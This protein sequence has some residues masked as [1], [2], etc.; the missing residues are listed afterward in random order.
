[1]STAGEAASLFGA[2][3]T[4]SDPFAVALGGEDDAPNQVTGDVPASDVAA[5][6]FGSATDAFPVGG[7][8]LEGSQPAAPAHHSWYEPPGQQ[9]YSYDNTATSTYAPTYSDQ[10]TYSQQNGYSQYS[11]YGQ[12]SAP[13][14]SVYEP[15]Y[16]QPQSYAPQAYSSYGQGDSP[17]AP[18]SMQQQAPTTQPGTYSA[19]AYDPYKPS[20]PTSSYDPPSSHAA[21]SVS[22]STY[23][24]YKPSYTA[25]ST[26]YEPPA[27]QAS[28]TSSTY[29]PGIANPP[30]AIPPPPAPLASAPAPPPPEVKVETYRPKKLNAYDPP[31]PPIKAPKHVPVP[32]V[33][34]FN[35]PP[36]MSPPRSTF[37][38]Q[39]LQPPPPTQGP[40]RS[41]RP[42]AATAPPRRDTQSSVQSAVPHHPPGPYA[43]PQLNG[44]AQPSPYTPSYDPVSHGVGYGSIGHSGLSGPP[45]A[46]LRVRD[47]LARPAND[48][49]PSNVPTYNQPEP[50][51]DF[52]GASS[53]P[54]SD[55]RT[56]DIFP[57]QQIASPS[58]GDLLD[59]ED[60]TPQA[61]SYGFTAKTE[62]PVS[63]PS[64]PPKAARSP[65]SPV[66]FRSNGS[67]HQSPVRR[68]PSSPER[69]KSPTK[70]SSVASRSLPSREA[71]SYPPDPYAPPRADASDRAKSPGA[72]SIRSLQSP[73]GQAYEPSPKGGPVASPPLSRPLS[74]Q[75]RRS[76]LS[77]AY[78]PQYVPD[79]KRAA[80]PAASIRSVNAPKQNA[81]DPYAPSEKP[82]SLPSMHSRTMSNGSAYSNASVPDPYAPSRYP[83]RQSSEHTYSSF[84]LPAQNGSYAPPA[85][86]Y[87]RMGGQV[88]TLAAPVHSTYAPSPSL[89]G[90][91][92]PLGRTSAR[93]PV[94]SFGFG[95]KLVTC[96][97]GANMNTG[98]D[99]ALSA[100]QS[101]DIK[102]HSLNKVVP[103]S[104]LDTSAASYPGPLFS[105]PGSPT[106]SLV[107]T[108]ATQLKT[109]KARVIKYLEERAEEIN[110][111][112][113]YHRPGS[114]DR[115]RAEAKRILVLL[116][117]AMVEHDGRLSGSNEIDAAV[118][119]ALLPD[120][121]TTTSQVDGPMGSSTMI[122]ASSS[123]LLAASQYPL[124][125]ALPNTQD[126]TVATTV[127]RSSHLD[128]IQT[129][130]AM[131][132]RRGACHYAAD[133][134]LWSHALVIASSIDKETWKDVVTEWIRAELASNGAQGQGD[135]GR[136]ALR[137]AYSLFGGNGAAA[138]Q[139]LVAPSKLLQH[140][141]TL[142]IPQPP[143][144]ITPMTPNF[145][146]VQPL[147]VPQE[148]LANWAK[149]AAM[150]LTNP[151]TV[152]CSA[153]LTALGDQLFAHQ[154]AEAA[155][156][157]YLLSPQ[158]SPLAALGSHPRLTLLGSLSPSTSPIY[159]KDP[160]PII[161]SEIAEFAMSL[162]TP[163]KG[164]DAFAGLPHLQP[165]RL[166]RASYLAEMGHVQAANRY[167]EAITACLNRG[168]P[169]FNIS[170]VEQLK[171]LTDRLTAAPQLDKSGSWIPG[172]M[173]KPSLDSIGGWLERGITKFIAGE[174]DSPRPEE[175]K[176]MA[177]QQSYSGPFANYSSI[178]SA[179]S[180]AHPS[181]HQSVTDLTELVNPAPPFRTGSAMGGARPPSRSQFP[182]SRASSAM[183]YGRP[184]QRTGSPIAR[185]ASASAA[186]FADAPSSYGQSRGPYGNGYGYVP[187]QGSD[188]LT[189]EG[190]SHADV[191][192]GY[193]HSKPPSAT[194]SWWGP[195]D[196]D[197]ATTPTASTFGNGDDQASS[198][199]SNSGFISLMDDPMLSMTP[200]ATKQQGSPLPRPSQHSIEEE[201][202]DDLG[203]GNS[204]L[205]PKK[206]DKAENGDAADSPAAKEEEKPKPADPPKP[207]VKQTASS[208][209]LSRLWRRG[210]TPTPGPVKANLGEE[211]SF[212]YDKELKRWVNKNS[213]ADASKPA[214]PPPPPRAQTASPG[215]SFGAMPPSSPVGPPPARPATAHPIDLTAEPPRRAAPPRVRSNLVPTD[216][217]GPSA[218][219]SPMPPM[220]STPPPGGGPPPASASRSRPG[221]K[222]NVRSRYVDVFQQEAS[223]GG[224]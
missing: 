132:D 219:P 206:A 77:N 50:G 95:G 109:K 58:Q 196:S 198:S 177:S 33:Q 62:I 152:D 103:E 82:S 178:S 65:A 173:S 108:G 130:L 221:V 189:A 26:T 183:D 179:T 138:V 52:W 92:D 170:F 38:A 217:D 18:T 45:P 76:T 155:H 176:G 79:P 35:T 150:L 100:R 39:P 163:A 166:L 105:D 107:R 185:V 208:G 86:P 124:A 195:S 149:T 34:T 24:P 64:S 182:I 74:S 223:A 31:L 17:Y 119:V 66:S 164:Q 90:T 80:S 57:S 135:E 94:I 158:T 81:Y 154:W 43:P 172:K 134:K 133:E 190:G 191:S 180:S 209:W 159:F 47:D 116:L 169:Y 204:S 98:F 218:P 118:R 192:S 201:D 21:P 120:L 143:V 42:P 36:P 73:P 215:R 194:G 153:A 97:H 220:G 16:S 12:T 10:T 131:G 125:S 141:P 110:S 56:E 49:Q 186:S 187:A 156:V 91:N 106:T 61:G 60:A 20:Q 213:A 84:A 6:L 214:P 142:Q 46:S 88:V 4:A 160:D 25:P 147:N 69:S 212:Y 113:G 8:S 55:D 87:D 144:S 151:M 114:V 48:T 14:T 137:V 193:G 126:H 41:P 101:T 161:F 83:V 59:P 85:A 93:V 102:I 78:E 44:T 167:C 139:E 15:N 128:K 188:H 11:Q 157:C 29:A 13:A 30:V 89:L 203:L 140:P 40:P 71:L 19:S 7:E 202:E 146:V 171:I 122:P 27:Q 112:L 111:G 216:A 162:A 148:V 136:E 104:A 53:P 211:S 9:T 75:S 200:T 205:K 165:Y 115:S 175:S 145:P 224:S 96:F 72:S 174:G 63:P 37:A 67:R 129:L 28:Y 121:G 1:M 222:R 127:L 197:A 5:D 54:A 22:S 207:E 32:P 51:S 23:D 68:G 70:P 2:A 168:A 117:K 123:E 3:D 210:E 99:V 199:T 181:P 184:Y